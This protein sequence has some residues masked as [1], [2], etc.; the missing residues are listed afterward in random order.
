[1]GKVKLEVYEEDV[2]KT[3]DNH[4]DQE[5]VFRDLFPTLFEDKEKFCVLNDVFLREGT[6]S[7]YQ[8]RETKEGNL[9]IYNISTNKFWATEIA[10][11]Y[12]GVVM[13]TAYRDITVGMLKRL[14]R[15]QTKD[16]AKFIVLNAYDLQKILKKR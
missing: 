13:G 3:I 2:L 14:A 4:P 15:S 1:M 10:N 16:I 7:F 11:P 6:G 8:V 12:R 5:A 9:A